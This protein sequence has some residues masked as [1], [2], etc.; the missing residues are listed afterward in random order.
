MD[1]GLQ[2]IFSSYGWD[3]VSD[4]AVYAQELAMAELAEELGFDAV[5]PT[6][7]HFFDYSFC[8]DNLELLA[9]VA[10]RTRKIGLGTAMDESRDRFDEASA[11]IVEALETGFIEGDGPMYPQVRT[12]I[13]PRPER[14]FAGRIYA[15]ANSRDSVEACARVG[16][17]MIMFSEAHWERRLPS[18]E[19]Y[20]ERYRH[21][22]GT[23]APPTMTADFTFC[24]EDPV[25]ARERAEA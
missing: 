7:H 23:E 5:W 12:E 17:R 1:V 20:R 24:H 4:A 3:D 18:I 14:S 25:Y 8:P 6:E 21:Y 19:H 9:Y 16:G 11:M 13:R 10:G 22:H 2:L 15:V